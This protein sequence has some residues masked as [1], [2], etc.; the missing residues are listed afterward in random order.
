MLIRKEKNFTFVFILGLVLIIIGL[1]YGILNKN[2]GILLLLL[3]FGLFFI[4]I[5]IY[6][7]LKRYQ[8]LK[9]LKEQIAKENFYLGRVVRVSPVNSYVAKTLKEKVY[10]FY[11]ETKI[12]EKNITLTSEWLEKNDLEQYKIVPD[13]EIKIA[14]FD[15][16]NYYF[17]L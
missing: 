3:I 8:H 7:N 12:D 5:A 13:Q 6:K 1:I 16:N 14:Y 17:F 11:V 10:E 2:I 15:D 9:K 4:G